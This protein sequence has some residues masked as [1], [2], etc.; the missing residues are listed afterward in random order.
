MK[1]GYH[2]GMSHGGDGSWAAATKVHLHCGGQGRHQGWPSIGIAP[3]GMPAH[4]QDASWV[5]RDKPNATEGD[6]GKEANQMKTQHERN[7]AVNGRTGIAG[8]PAFQSPSTYPVLS[9]TRVTKWMAGCHVVMSEGR[10][11]RVCPQVARLT[12]P[13][14]S[15]VACGDLVTYLGA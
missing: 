7:Q 11:Y 4:N 6:G 2:L 1:C 15:G 10:K 14:R 9:G 8:V 5:H 12:S 3:C 13:I